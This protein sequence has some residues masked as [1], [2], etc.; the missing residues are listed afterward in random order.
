MFSGEGDAGVR[1][2]GCASVAKC[3][4]TGFPLQVSILPAP[5]ADETT[6]G[7]ID[8]I[9]SSLDKPSV[10]VCRQHGAHGEGACRALGYRDYLLAVGVS[11]DEFEY[12]LRSPTHEVET[13]HRGRMAL[14]WASAQEWPPTDRPGDSGWCLA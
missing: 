13:C 10:L 7:W 3:S 9:L 12:A 8:H 1:L 11:K 6:L 4:L 2:V 14:I 5:N